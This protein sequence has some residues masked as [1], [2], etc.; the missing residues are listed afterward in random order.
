M[1]SII[2]IHSL[3]NSYGDI[4]AVRGLTINVKE[5]ELFG[6]I[7]PDG[8][9]K[10]TTLRTICGLLSRDSG[11]VKVFGI[12]PG[13]Q[14]RKVREYLG[15]M[16]QRFSLY[17]DL[18]VSENLRF[19]ADLYLV[20]RNERVKREERLMQFSR[21]GAFRDRRAHQLSGGMKQK[22]AL[23]CTLIH[24]PKLLILDEPT[25]GV[26]PV[27]RREFWTILKELS[28]EGI[29]QIVS[30]P[31]MDEAR[32]CDRTA[33]MHRGTTL[34]IGTPEE[35]TRLYPDVLVEATGENLNGIRQVLLSK[36]FEANRIHRFGG[37]LHVAC[38]N[39]HEADS[40]SAYIE[41]AGGRAVRAAPTIE[42]TFVA[43]IQQNSHE[44]GDI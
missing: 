40:I 17:P 35:I 24:T 8:A 27:S 43:M 28:N 36:D 30:T 4:Q 13:Q 18:T 39:G 29:T 12:D 2:E 20:P 44:T 38:R 9:G 22:L 42:D 14:S 26:D 25:T 34:A 33:L 5:G 23:C 10:T 6:L 16:P 32:L 31:Y 1:N 3:V 21:L 41:A 7:G 37:K 15:Y 11:S 19:F